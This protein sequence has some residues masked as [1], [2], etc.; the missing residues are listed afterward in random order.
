MECF[1]KSSLEVTRTFSQQ[2]CFTE[3]N[4]TLHQAHKLHNKQ[5]VGF[6]ELP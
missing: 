1:S 2:L 6:N 4:D 5:L 3:I